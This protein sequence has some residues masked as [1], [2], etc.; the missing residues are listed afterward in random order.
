MA[1]QAGYPPVCASACAGA[2]GVLPLP[3]AAVACEDLRIRLYNLAGEEDVINV[4]SVMHGAEFIRLIQPI[5]PCSEP[6]LVRPLFQGATIDEHATLA[7]NGLTDDSEITCIFHAASIHEM[8]GAVI[9]YEDDSSDMTLEEELIF[10]SL[11]ELPVGV[12]SLPERPPLPG[13]LRHLVCHSDF[14]QSLLEIELPSG[15]QSLSLGGHFN[16][17]MDNVMLPQGLQ[18]LTFGGNFDQSIE[19]LRLPS[20]LQTLEFGFDFNQRM[21]RVA[22]PPL[23]QSLTFGNNFKQG[24]EKVALP[25]ALKSLAFGA[26]FNKS[27]EKVALPRSLESLTLGDGF[28]RSLANVDLPENLQRLTFGNDFNQSMQGVSIPRG[29]KSLTFGERYNQDMRDVPLPSGLQS[30]TFGTCFDQDAVLLCCS[31][32]LQLTG[33]ISTIRLIKK[34]N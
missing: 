26:K 19:K 31:L 4:R 22:F 29:V 6:G 28:N 16:E 11:Q 10:A 14:A 30:L 33:C 3:A 32:L 18:S 24:L 20:A 2:A 34:S 7:E 23:L 25:S 13:T 12:R 15:L 17:H 27:L 9:A 5:P 21:D 1:E 8:Q